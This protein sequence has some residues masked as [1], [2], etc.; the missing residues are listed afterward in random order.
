MRC[1]F[2]KLLKREEKKGSTS[3][4]LFDESFAHTYLPPVVAAIVTARRPTAPDVLGCARP[5]GTFLL[6]H[7]L[8]TVITVIRRCL[9]D[10]IPVAVTLRG[11]VPALPPMHEQ[12]EETTSSQQMLES[13]RW[14]A[15]SRS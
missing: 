5:V 15:A 2:L 9:A 4:S 13:K 11:R 12:R 8:M 14:H 7:L 3:S 6:E 10:K 1:H